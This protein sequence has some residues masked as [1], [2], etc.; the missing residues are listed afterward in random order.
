MTKTKNKRLFRV[1]IVALCICTLT[2][3]YLLQRPAYTPPLNKVGFF[4]ESS[5]FVPLKISAFSRANIP[6]LEV[7]IENTIISAKV[8]LGWGGGVRVP[9]GIIQTI[10]KK[11]FITKGTS[12]GLRGKTYEC[13][14][15]EVPKIYL[16][17]MKIFPMRI[18]EENLEFAKDAVLKN[19]DKEIDEKHLGRVGWYVFKSVNVLLDCEHSTIVACDSLDTLRQQGYR[20]EAF[21]EA[22]LLLDRD[23]I[24]FEV[25]T[26]IG[27][28]RCT[29]DTGSTWNFLNKDLEKPNQNHRPRPSQ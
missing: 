18:A 23:S 10:K 6:Q 27:P 1:L 14:I 9:P 17:K 3:V 20:I 4:N 8:D 24:D 21:I 29:L 12:C 5:H 22:P 25:V 26:E 13:D 16:G 15:Y 2:S 28:L 7:E 19:G 11:S